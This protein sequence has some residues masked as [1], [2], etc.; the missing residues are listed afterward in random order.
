MLSSSGILQGIPFICQFS[1]CWPCGSHTP[2]PGSA[3]CMFFVFTLLDQV[4]LH[5]CFCLLE[6]FPACHSSALAGGTNAYTAGS[7]SDWSYPYLA[8]GNHCYHWRVHPRTSWWRTHHTMSHQRLYQSSLTRGHYSGHNKI[9]SHREPTRR[10][11]QRCWYMFLEGFI[12]QLCIHFQLF[13][14]IVGILSILQAFYSCFWTSL[15]SV[16]CTQQPEY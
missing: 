3:C 9:L 7:Y 6:D 16:S 13:L 5:V 11:E 8:C 10:P 1:C 12:R 15:W 2:L 4:E 14:D